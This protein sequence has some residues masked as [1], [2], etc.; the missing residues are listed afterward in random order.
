MKFDFALGHFGSGKTILGVEVAK[1]MIAR[2]LDHGENVKAYVL[3]FDGVAGVSGLELD[4]TLLNFELEDKYFQVY[5]NLIQ[6]SHWNDFV[7]K[8]A[9]DHEDI[10]TPE[11]STLIKKKTGYYENG[12][13]DLKSVLEIIAG[14]L[15]E[16]AHMKYIIM[17]DEVI[18]RY[19]VVQ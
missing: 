16:N 17:V 3:T 14:I 11:E 10:L 1:I 5:K 13:E 18:I 19:A 4:Y 8:F 6:I 7:K 2:L 9:Q 12:G 15:N